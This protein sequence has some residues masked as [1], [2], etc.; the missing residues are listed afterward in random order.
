MLNKPRAQNETVTEESHAA[1]RTML[2]YLALR[3]QVEP[4]RGSSLDRRR[5]RS[6]LGR[7][8]RF[9]RYERLVDQ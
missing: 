4:Q 7:R 9:E 8:Q 1:N 5:E 2:M 6:R 3:T